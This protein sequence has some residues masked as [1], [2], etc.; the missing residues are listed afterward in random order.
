MDI[1]SPADVLVLKVAFGASVAYGVQKLISHTSQKPVVEP[2]IPPRSKTSNLTSNILATPSRNIKTELKRTRKSCMIFYGS[3]TGTAEKLASIFA[4]EALFRFGV[5]GLV[6]DLDNF[7]YDDLLSL[8]E[9]NVLVF[10][11]ATYGEG[12]PTDNSI[13]FDRY[14]ANLRSKTDLQAH[15]LHYASF[16]LGNSSYQFYN[17]MI[18]RVD[19]TLSGAGAHRI[20]SAG[21]G[22]DADGSLEDDFLTWK[23]E[24]LP[25]LANHL[26][27]T[28]Q[29]RAPIVNLV[30]S[31]TKSSSSIPLF[32]GEPNAAHRKGKLRGPWT[33]SNPL[34]ARI[35]ESREVFQNSPRKCL[36]VAFDISDSTMTY[37]TGD[38]LGV[39]PENSNREVERF[40]RIFGLFE[41]KD[42]IFNIGSEDP[43]VKLPL[44]AYTTY[45]AA[46][47]YYLDIC[48]PISRYIL[49]SLVSYCSD[50]VTKAE[51]LRLS[52]DNVAFE[53][54]VKN[55]CLN[56]AQFLEGFGSSTLWN[57]VPI[58]LLFEMIGKLQPRYY[59]ISSSSLQSRKCIS[60]TAVVET[61]KNDEWSHEFKGVATNYLLAQHFQIRGPNALEPTH[62]LSGP[63]FRNTAMSSLIHVRRSKFR[64]PKMN[65]VPII[66]IGPGTG[67]A[68]FRAFVQERAWQ[69]SAHP[70][71]RT[72]LFYGCRRRN[73]D[74][75]YE[76]EWRQLETSFKP[77][78]FSMH[79]AFSRQ[80]PTKKVY[81]QHLLNQQAEELRELILRQNACVY[82]CG[83]AQRMAKDVFTAMAQIIGED[84]AFDGDS[85]AYLKTLKKNKRWLEDVW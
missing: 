19:S 35:S 49:G 80:D 51:L 45:D 29:E 10:L 8:S 39:S 59:S 1:F 25:Q 22:D 46:T 56:L 32:L 58:S 75:L 74:F 16:G 18:K 70:A 53:K 30:I 64:L 7:D 47:R 82:V 52:K 77:G 43:T 2:L 68:P 79:V 14:C 71:G 69:N 50:E 57:S 5:E 9:E 65:S 41:K 6:A 42:S 15:N 38:H 26:G 28:E 62:L 12:D 21:L 27:F 37:E 31:E 24:T 84:N 67:I 63:R 4:K 83:D 48:A 78:T 54:E 66:M 36:H 23:D 13:S 20:G 44:P 72:I 33:N 11:L 3:Q 60:I 55:L 34:P 17:E 61:Q 73:E 85:Q 40:L 81:V 76:E